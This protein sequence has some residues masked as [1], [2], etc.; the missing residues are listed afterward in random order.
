MIGTT[1]S[2]YHI[3]AKLGG[4]GM[5]V[6]YKAEDTDLRRFVA[7]KFLPPEVAGDPQALARFR[8]EAQ[9]ASAL[10]HHNICTIYEIG[11]YEG[12]S[13]IVMEFLDGVTLKHQIGGQPLEI[14]LLL[15]LGTEIADAL[16]AAHTE[17][18]I[19]R[20]IKPANIFVTRRGHAKI[21]DFG[22]AKVAAKAAATGLTATALEPSDAHH[23]TS[24]GSIPGTTAYM[25]PE[26]LRGQELDGRSD[27]FSFGAVLYEMATGRMPFDRGT[28]SETISTILRDEPRPA[29]RLNPAVSAELDAVLRKALEKDR[30]LRYQHASDM[31]ADLRRLKRDSESTHH[32]RPSSAGAG[33]AVGAASH[34]PSSSGAAAIAV[35]KKHKLAVL[36]GV[37][38][39]VS[40][41]AAAGLGVYSVLNRTATTPFQNFTVTQITNS[42]KAARTAISPDGKF[43]IS[44]IDE[45]GLQ[46][47]WLRNVPTGS[48]TQVI[49]PSAADYE[50]LAFSPDENYIYFRKAV[51]ATGSQFDLYRAPVLGGTQRVVVR[52]IDSDFAFSPDGRRIAFSRANDPD[53]GKYRLITAAVNGEDEKVVL[54]GDANDLAHHLAWSPAGNQLARQVV[55]PGDDL[56]GIDAI[57]LDTGKARRL[58]A[59]SHKLPLD[60]KWA[61]D[62]RGIFMTYSAKGPYFVRGQ[63]GF[64]SS[65][66]EKFEPI[67]RD[68]NGYITLSISADGRT[69]ATVQKKNSHDIYVISGEGSSS[70]QV[71]ALSSAV[72]DVHWLNWGGNGELLA[73]DGARLW[74]VASDGSNPN[75]LLADPSADISDL[76]NCGR[77]YIVFAWQFHEGTTSAIWRVDAD[78]S[79]PVRLTRGKHDR[80]PVCTPDQQWV[81]YSGEAAGND[82]MY[83][84]K[85]DG[86]GAPEP[87]PGSSNFRG[88]ILPAPIALPARSS[89]PVEAGVSADGKILAYAADEITADTEEAVESIALLNLESP[90]SP[91]LLRANRHRSG[92]VQFTPD[93]KAVAYPIRENGV[94][95]IWVQPLDGSAGHL[96][97]HFTSDQIDSFHWSPDGKSLALLRSHSESDVVL[98]Q[99]SKP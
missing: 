83:R 78:G 1:I 73:R 11:N 53:V 91:R 5:G 16:D 24:P 84:V 35:V 67:T 37:I 66:G 2:H 80:D 20:D 81:Y 98:L 64:L 60:L 6:V 42:G 4:G 34:E 23:L 13:F 31:R 88:Y 27:L 55:A 95:N 29:G 97:T 62:G 26:Q 32:I 38:A 15:D 90:T 63:I 39:V 19:H 30:D 61:P 46:S 58:A 28:S 86:S 77:Q 69:L 99:E 14:E 75:Q 93:G 22:L 94:D 45:N 51:T 47:L 71:N 89:R 65:P 56:G 70:A 41:L 33:T 74:R 17:G 18:I 21:L 8:R 68:T 52:D 76:A 25:S 96:L 85:L 59:F 92:G 57:D 82:Q 44:V 49:A 79:N 54:I 36:A 50:S 3:I 87:L 9:A 43:V 10:N 12:Q 48:D 7:V 40:V 72:A